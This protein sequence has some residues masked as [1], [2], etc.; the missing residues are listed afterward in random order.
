MPY[1]MF[2]DD[3]FIYSL[4]AEMNKKLKHHRF[5]HSAAV[6][7]T[8]ASLA[9]KYGEDCSKAVVA[10]ILHDCAKCYDDDELVE[11]CLKNDIPVS[12]FEKDHGFILH[13]KYGAYLAKNKYG[14]DDEDILNAIR[15]HTTGHEDM[16]LLEK[17]IFVSDY[18]EPL[19]NKAQ[20][21]DKI[22]NAAFNEDDIDICVV[23]IM[24]DTIEYLKRSR[25]DIDTVTKAAYDYLNARIGLYDE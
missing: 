12:G 1:T 25:Y 14:I 8:A 9:M 6:A 24:H 15:W 16:T 17:I 23:M 7:G 20:N 3:K 4:Y 2:S 10:G 22:R 18:I 11:L 13:A 19:R 5:I 21:L